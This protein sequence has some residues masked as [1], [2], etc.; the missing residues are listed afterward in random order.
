MRAVITDIEGTTTPIA[1][2]HDV[3]FPFARKYFPVFV[4]TH[5][6]EP[7]VAGA[8]REI[9]ALAPGQDVLT[10]I[11]GLMDR[12]EKST[13]LKS[14]QGMIWDRGYREGHLHSAIYPDVAPH[15]LAWHRGGIT[16]GIYSSG[17]VAAQRLL[18]GHTLS[19]DLTGYFSYFFDTHIGGKREAAS[20]RAIQTRLG[21]AADDILFLSDIGAELEAA[22]E[23]GFATCQLLRAGDHTLA[24]DGHAQAADFADVAKLFLLP[25]A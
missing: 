4:Q 18:F 17:S 25:R 10:I 21:V 12:D 5:G 1:F 14:L 24:A 23:A 6:A 13:P 15:I 20:Y 16:L 9:A 8:L 3:L 7:L 22:R 11:F 2:V 19:G